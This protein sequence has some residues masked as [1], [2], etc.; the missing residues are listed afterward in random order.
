[1]NRLF[2]SAAISTVLVVG[3]NGDTPAPLAEYERG[4]FALFSQLEKNAEANENVVYSPVSVQQ[5]F[6]LVQLGAQGETAQQIEQVLDI[7]RGERGA[8]RMRERREVLTR[9][10]DGVSVKIA[11]A[12]FLSDK[13]QFAETYIEAAREF[14]DARTATLD[15]ASEPQ[16]AASTINR[17]ASNATDHEIPA[18]IDASK[19]NPDAAAY[20]ANATFFEGEWSQPF[21]S[22][23][24]KSFLRGDGTEQV[25]DLMEGQLSIRYAENAMW[26][27]VRLPYGP[28]SQS[29][30]RFVMDVMIPADRRGDS[31]RLS[32]N[33]IRQLSDQLDLADAQDVHIWMPRFEAE[34]QRDLIAPL[35]MAGLT[36]PFD[37]ARADLSS[38]SALNQ[39]RLFIE[40]AFQAATVKVFNTGTRAAAVTMVVPVPVNIPPPFD[41]LDFTVDRP[42]YFVIRDLER[43]E[44][45]FLGKITNPGRLND[46]E[47]GALISH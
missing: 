44:V 47:S 10:S 6:G 3:C 27:A 37:R 18:V 21:R 23:Q 41:G 43:D 26:R 22:T 13:W 45:I 35:R 20:L 11:N 28:A 40:Q 4:E 31:R 39:P 16:D 2:I 1:M 5:A 9:E 30:A 34:M 15:F 17:W 46:G 12:L 33:G 38:M 19:I 8:A 29:Q 24:K 42:F 36:L 25:I 32:L 7:G 14:Y